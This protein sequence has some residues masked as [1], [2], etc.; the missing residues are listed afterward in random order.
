MP[1]QVTARLAHQVQSAQQLRRM[2]LIPLAEERW[3]CIEI[4]A[5]AEIATSICPDE[6]PIPPHGRRAGRT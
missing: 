2:N 3:G 1:R 5:I 6:S 4:M